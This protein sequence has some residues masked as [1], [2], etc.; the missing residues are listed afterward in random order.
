[1]EA[2]G[3]YSWLPLG[4]RVLQRVTKIVREEMNRIGALEVSLPIAQPA[5][6]WQQSGRWE[7]YG[8][9]LQRFEDRR[10]RMFC[11]G[12]THEEVICALARDSLNSYRDLPVTYYQIQT[13]YRGELRPRFGLMRCREFLMK[14]AYSFHADTASLE[15]SYRQMHGAYCRIL[16]RLGLDYRVVAADSGTIGGDTSEEFQ[17][18]AAAGEDTIVVSEGGQYAANLEQASA[19]T[20]VPATCASPLCELQQME[21]PDQHTMEEVCELLKLELCDTVKTLVVR[22]SQPEQPLIALVLRGDDRLNAVKAAHLPEIASPLEMAS[23]EEIRA[24]MGAG[25]GSLGPVDAPI[26]VLV[27][28]KAAARR[29]FCCGANR[30]G[31]HYLNANWERDAEIGQVCDLREVQDGDPSPCGD[32]K[33]HLTRG[34]EVG[35]IFQLGDKYSKP[36]KVRVNDSNKNPLTPLMGCY[37]MGV[38]RI[39]AAAIEQN[40]DDK[41]ILWPE[42]MA[43][44]QLQ[45]I[46]LSGG[47]IA[48]F[49]EQLYNE[50][51]HTDLD[52][53]LD[54]RPLRAGVKLTDFELIGVP[55]ALILGERNFQQNQL[56]YRNRS[57]GDTRILPLQNVAQEVQIA[58]QSQP[59]K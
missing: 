18:L 21:T 48:D 9:E 30:D 45:I 2:A 41:G 37:G 59:K 11:L 29:N 32:G 28:T 53:L 4:L 36:M 8:P 46:P 43:P 25:S 1:M 33:L 34:I 44:F 12:P 7:Q 13:K 24:S 56:E 57:T 49:A 16:D 47:K 20:Q 15:D 54:D 19:N 10:G 27:D 3:I 52:V 39:L 17:V 40:H 38:S 42:S 31:F 50:L 6:L 51:L 22:G 26:P 23:D 58:L 35:H 5:E 55:H 14:D